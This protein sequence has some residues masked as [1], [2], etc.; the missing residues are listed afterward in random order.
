MI[1]HYVKIW[2]QSA[3]ARRSYDVGKSL[4][5]FFGPPCI[6]QMSRLYLLHLFVCQTEFPFAS[7][8]SHVSDH[9]RK[10]DFGHGLALENAPTVKKRAKSVGRNANCRCS[11]P[12]NGI[13]R[14][15]RQFLKW[16]S[17]FR[18]FFL[19]KFA[20]RYLTTERLRYAPYHRMNSKIRTH[21][22][23]NPALFA[24]VWWIS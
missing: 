8:V 24:C 1:K 10:S 21:A 4:V 3:N 22:W 11:I 23:V 14:L 6:W 17:R 5:V 7:R 15:F 9:G 18:P 16:F 20:C 2:Q 12:K 13:S 19:W